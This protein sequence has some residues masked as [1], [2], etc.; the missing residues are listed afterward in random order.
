MDVLWTRISSV[1]LCICV[2]VES[3]V[4]VIDG[5]YF[6]LR[7][8]SRILL[9]CDQK[10]TADLRESSSESHLLLPIAGTSLP[11]ENA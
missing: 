3:R 8:K 9:G 10:Q 4:P 1:D 11:N 7:L 2:N 5:C 6:S